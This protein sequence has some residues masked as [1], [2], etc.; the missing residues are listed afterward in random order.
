MLFR[1]SGSEAT[2]VSPLEAAPVKRAFFTMERNPLLVDAYKTYENYIRANMV[3]YPY[4]KNAIVDNN[5]K[6]NTKLL[7][8]ESFTDDDGVVKPKYPAAK[9]ANE[10]TAGGLEWW[11]PSFEEMLLLIGKVGGLDDPI[12]RSLT[13]ISGGA[14][15][16]STSHWSSSEY[17]SGNA[18]FYSGIGGMYGNGRNYAYA[19]RAV[20]AF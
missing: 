2:N 5:G 6:R 3:R 16:N 19:V 1:S 14:L 12:N 17:S 10:Q 4:S 7:S 8:G 20:S 15:T 11:L 9:K 18:W 13:A